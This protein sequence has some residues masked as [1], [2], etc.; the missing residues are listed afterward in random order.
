MPTVETVRG[1]V[2]LDELGRTLMHEH[3]FLL[4]P[5]ALENFGTLWGGSSYWDEEERV[6]DAIEKLGAVREAGIR[7]IVDPTAVGLGRYI[8]RI[9]RLN[10][11]VDLNILVATGVYAFLQLP[12]FL[13]YRSVEAI[14]EIFVRELR[15]A[16]TT[17]AS[18]RRS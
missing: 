13:G 6:A 16:S 5:E 1:P 8:P 14:A 11:S 7:T 17:P 3:V 18:R 4:E 15:E 12:N 10:E 2:D 9:Q